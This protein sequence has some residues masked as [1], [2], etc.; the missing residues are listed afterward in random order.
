MASRE[1]M[2]VIRSSTNISVTER[3]FLVIK[4]VLVRQ[5]QSIPPMV[6]ASLRCLTKICELASC[7]TE[8][9]REKVTERGKL[10][11]MA[12]SIVKVT[13]IASTTLWRV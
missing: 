13:S 5:R 12:T 8:C 11:G 9:A 4:P 1:M 2:L 7:L 3:R 10:S 6:S